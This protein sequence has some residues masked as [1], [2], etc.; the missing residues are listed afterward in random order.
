MIQI[1]GMYFDA[2]V[3]E[4]KYFFYFYSDSLWP[5]C[6]QTTNALKFLTHIVLAIGGVTYLPLKGK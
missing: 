2:V 4:F 6:A 3:V 5:Y 1:L